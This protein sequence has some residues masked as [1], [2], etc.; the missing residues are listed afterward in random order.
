MH[1][2]A[3]FSRLSLP[4]PTQGSF[5]VELQPQF[6][7]GTC[8]CSDHLPQAQICLRPE[9]AHDY[10]VLRTEIRVKSPAQAS[11]RCLSSVP[12]TLVRFGPKNSGIPLISGAPPPNFLASADKT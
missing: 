12:V 9:Q 7:G 1:V 8:G 6:C 11:R 3:A 4:F 10:G 5:G 2:E